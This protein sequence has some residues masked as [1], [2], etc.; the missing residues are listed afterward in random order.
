MISITIHTIHVHSPWI[1]LDNYVSALHLKDQEGMIWQEIEDKQISTT[2]I[3]ELRKE[4]WKVKYD[5][6][7]DLGR[8]DYENKI[9]FLSSLFRFFYSPFERDV[10][11][12]HELA[13]VRHPTVLNSVSYSS[14]PNHQ[15]EIITEWLGRKAR[16]D[17]E[18]LHHAVLSFG[19]KPQ[20]YDR[21]SYCAFKELSITP[22]DTKTLD[23]IL[24]D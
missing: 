4:G 17:P 11:L 3:D 24:M 7:E 12:F 1:E 19:L 10:T 21:A 8:C 23:E 6:I 14:I 9:I 18:L 15:Q 16:A 2:F 20:I 22:Y 5:C 13:H